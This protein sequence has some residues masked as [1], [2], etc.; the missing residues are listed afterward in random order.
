MLTRVFEIFTQIDR[1]RERPQG[2]LGLG[3]TLAKELVEMHGGALEA[4]SAG[5]GAG[6]E[7]IVRLA[8]L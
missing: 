3:L 6:S 2:G 4:R 1:S 5:T 7:F 8:A